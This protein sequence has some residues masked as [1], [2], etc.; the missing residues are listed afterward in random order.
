MPALASH[1]TV[2]SATHSANVEVSS[3]RI[4]SSGD[5]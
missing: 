5:R 4:G 1:H 2:S 3:T